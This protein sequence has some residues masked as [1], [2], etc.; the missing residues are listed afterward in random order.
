MRW[1]DGKALMRSC[2]PPWCWSPWDGSLSRLGRNQLCVVRGCFLHSEVR[3]VRRVRGGAASLGADDD[4][5][6]WVVSRC[7]VNRETIQ[8]VDT[9]RTSTR[10]KV[11]RGHHFF[12]LVSSLAGSLPSS[13]SSFVHYLQA[14]KDAM[15]NPLFAQFLTQVSGCTASTKR[16]S[17]HTQESVGWGRLG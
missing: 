3:R 5:V 13:S 15:S 1:D 2:L 14:L 17:L 8:V 6:I 9:D 7:R 16:V 11:C 4:L 12:A 10:V